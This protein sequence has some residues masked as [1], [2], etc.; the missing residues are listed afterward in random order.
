MQLAEQLKSAYADV[1]QQVPDKRE[2]SGYV[3]IE[4]LPQDDYTDI[5][6]NKTVE[7]VDH[8]IECGADRLI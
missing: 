5:T 1:C 7:T 4:L 8:L 3:H 2:D 6:L